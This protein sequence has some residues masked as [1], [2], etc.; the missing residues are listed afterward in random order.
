MSS[1]VVD[2]KALFRGRLKRTALA[3]AVATA[4]AIPMALSLPVAAHAADTYYIR[5]PYTSMS[6]CVSALEKRA[7]ISGN[8]VIGCTRLPASSTGP[9]GYYFWSTR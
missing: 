1:A 9:A 7:Q 4:L 8:K 2:R 6:S 3:G 5:G